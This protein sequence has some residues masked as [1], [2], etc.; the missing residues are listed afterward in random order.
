MNCRECMNWIE[1]KDRAEVSC[2]VD[3]QAM[4]RID[5][6]SDTPLDH[7]KINYFKVLL[8]FFEFSGANDDCD[9]F[10]NRC[11][12]FVKEEQMEDAG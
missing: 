11:F 9:F 2:L 4:E 7:I 10:G 5:R 3:K 6:G 12:Y 8:E 1:D